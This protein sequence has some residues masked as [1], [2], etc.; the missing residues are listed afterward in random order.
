M[1]SDIGTY[2]WPLTTYAAFFFNLLCALY[3]IVLISTTVAVNRNVYF[4]IRI[5]DVLIITDMIRANKTRCNY[6]LF[7]NL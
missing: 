7:N 3:R 5:K 2:E 6:I 1:V 4:F